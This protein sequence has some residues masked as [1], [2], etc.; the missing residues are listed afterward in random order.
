MLCSPLIALVI[1][2]K[3]KIAEFTQSGR[4]CVPRREKK[5]FLIMRKERRVVLARFSIS[6]FVICFM[7]MEN[8]YA[9]N[10]IVK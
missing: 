6:H 2:V 3:E 1:I 4:K 9:S 5:S 7:N 10:C 8:L